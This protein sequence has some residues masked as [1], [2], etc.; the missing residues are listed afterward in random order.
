[1]GEIMN[2]HTKG[3]WEVNVLGQVI[4]RYE[5]KTNSY[6]M[7]IATIADTPESLGKPNL[8]N[9]RL[10]AAAPD[11]LELAELA[12]SELNYDTSMDTTRIS[13]RNRLR[14]TIAK[15]KWE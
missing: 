10:I 7:D 13:I 12:L 1:M 4:K 14:A 5:D 9:A 6:S 3:P 8:A 15:A 11:L 2:K